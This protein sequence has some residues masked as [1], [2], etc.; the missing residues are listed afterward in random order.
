MP[1]DPRDLANLIDDI[2]KDLTYAKA[3]FATLREWLAA[4]NLPES[5][6][7]HCPVDTCALPFA[8]A[9]QLADH[10]VNVHDYQRAPG[11]TAEARDPERLFLADLEQ[12]G[13]RELPPVA[14]DYLARLKAGDGQHTPAEPD[15]RPPEP[16]LT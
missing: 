4:M 12:A 6:T 16:S 15:L 14:A 7:H 9:A 5:R 11:E 1:V 2:Q 13:P 3:K 10:L 8:T